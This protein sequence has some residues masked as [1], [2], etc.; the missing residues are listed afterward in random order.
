[1]TDLFLF[2]LVLISIFVPNKTTKYTVTQEVEWLE[3][4]MVKKDIE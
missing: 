2:G 1:M 3:S 4:L